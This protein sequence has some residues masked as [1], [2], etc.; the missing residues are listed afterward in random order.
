MK[1]Y[2]HLTTFIM[3]LALAMIFI[4]CSK[5]PEITESNDATSAMQSA[6]SAGADKYAA[7]DME[8]A[9]KLMSDAD[10]QVKDKKYDEAKK[11]YTDAKV[12]FDKAAG[13]VEAGKK[14]VATEVTAAIDALGAPWKGIQAAAKKAGKAMGEKKEEWEADIK[15][16]DEGLKAAKETL[17]TEPADAKAKVDE[18][19]ALIEKWDTTF[20]EMAAAPVPE[21]KK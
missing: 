9:Y 4:G 6:V 21:A 10:A 16:F 18:L 11:T 14:V 12:A 7:T 3:I 2:K 17:A 1:Y 13:A 5:P 20:K 19:K 15:S 8:A